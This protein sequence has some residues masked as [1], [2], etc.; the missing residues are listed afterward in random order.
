MEQVF[1][2]ISYRKGA[3]VIRMIFSILGQDAFRA[4]L[5][6]YMRKH[7]YGNTETSDLWGAWEV[8]SG[9]PIG[10]L[11]ASWTEQMGFPVLLVTSATK[12]EGGVNLNIEQRWFLADGSEGDGRTWT[13]PV[14][15]ATSKNPDG[16]GKPEFFHSQVFSITVPAAEGEWIKLNAGQTVP[17]RVAYTP[18]LLDSLAI[19]IR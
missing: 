17:M 16:D 9:L 11:M 6:L 4:G 5:Q 15:I 10:Q 7:Q 8:T 12:V 13:V 1:D 14:R 3:S 19:G 2:A 18:A